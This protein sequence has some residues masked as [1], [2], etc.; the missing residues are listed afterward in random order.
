MQMSAKTKKTKA[1]K[2]EMS[3]VQDLYQF[4]YKA[5]GI[6]RKFVEH[7]SFKDKD[8][9]NLAKGGEELG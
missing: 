7:E 4:L 6:L 3:G 1:P 8:F 9:Y 5:C 2:E